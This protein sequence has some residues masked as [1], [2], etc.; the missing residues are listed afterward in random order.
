MEVLQLVNLVSLLKLVVDWLST[1]IASE[2]STPPSPLVLLVPLLPLLLNLNRLP[3]FRLESKLFSNKDYILVTTAA[4]FLKKH[5]DTKI[6]SE[7]CTPPPPSPSA[8]S[9]PS[10]LNLNRLPNFSQIQA[11]SKQRLHFSDDCSVVFKKIW[12]YRNR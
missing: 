6:A 7:H 10:L 1:E 4:L 5:G 3:N 9:L 2:L 8:P 11:V 12:G